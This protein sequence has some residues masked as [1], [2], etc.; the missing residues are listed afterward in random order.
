M[1][2]IGEVL[3]AFLDTADRLVSDLEAAALDLNAGEIHRAAHSL[4]SS[5]YSCGLMALGL[6]TEAAESAARTGK[7]EQAAAV[8]PE[9]RDAFEQA[10]TRVEG[11][12][13]EAA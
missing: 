10:R 1:V 7:A 8:V 4:K 3:E 2:F 12:L 6:R 5:A 13:A 9:I 11:F